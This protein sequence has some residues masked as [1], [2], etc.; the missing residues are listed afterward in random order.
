MRNSARKHSV[1]FPQQA[2]DGRRAEGDGSCWK[3]PVVVEAAGVV[4]IGVRA[5]L[6]PSVGA[7][8]APD[9]VGCSVREAV[10][11]SIFVPFL[12]TTS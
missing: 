5:V 4:L 1:R 8:L 11:E 10:V 9:A 7:H 12:L 3:K 2:L 6:D